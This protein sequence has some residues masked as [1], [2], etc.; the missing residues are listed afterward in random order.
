[1]LIA[2]LIPLGLAT[3]FYALAFV[4]AAIRRSAVPTLEGTVLGAITNF[5]DTLGIGSFAPT[6]AW[7]KFRKLVPDRLIPC[8]MIV[9]HTLPT[10]VQA[11]IFLVLL[12]VLVDPILLVG[13]TLSFLMG[14][15][16]GV[17]MVTRTRVWIVQVVVACGLILAAILYGLANLHMMPGGGTASGL[18]LSLTV[19]AMVASFIIGILLNFGIGNYAPTLVLLSLMGMD[20]RLCFPIMAASAGLTATATG[21]R[22]IAI[23]E[24]NLRLATGMAIGGIPAVLIAAFIVKSM[25]VETL[26]WGVIVVVLYAAAIMLRSAVIGRRDQIAT[27][28]C[29]SAE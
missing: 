4:R 6:M 12:G 1:M 16:L 22:Y 9:G 7:F 21:F 26:R 24:V 20:P 8:T 29:A 14:G 15:L 13:C 18:P 19:V 17:P 11:L 23:G 28:A 10:M 5:F 3:L 2:L 27:L 25:P